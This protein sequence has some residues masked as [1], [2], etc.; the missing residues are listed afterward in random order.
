M[1]NVSKQITCSYYNYVI[2]LMQM[3]HCPKYTKSTNKAD[4][5]LAYNK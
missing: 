4:N 5:L 3:Q 2:E 1:T